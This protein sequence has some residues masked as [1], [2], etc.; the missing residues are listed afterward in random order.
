MMI[1]IVMVTPGSTPPTSPTVVP[2][3]SGTKYWSW[4]TSPKLVK[5]GP[6]IAQNPVRRPRGSSTFRYASK[7]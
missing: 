6:N 5:S 1:V 7:R 3:T 4:R 2:I